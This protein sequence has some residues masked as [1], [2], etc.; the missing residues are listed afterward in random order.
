[1]IAGV[2]A[3]L[4]SV[5]NDHR[6]AEKQVREVGLQLAAI[7]PYLKDLRMVIFGI[8]CLPSSRRSSS[9]G[10]TRCMAMRVARDLWL[11]GRCRDQI[12]RCSPLD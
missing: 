9:P 3:Y 11:L 7:K 5:A 1:V 10:P 8:P 2:A 12:G 6:K 4:G